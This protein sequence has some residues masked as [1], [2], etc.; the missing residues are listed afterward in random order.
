MKFVH[1]ADMH[2]D[3]PFTM[4]NN[5][6][7][8]EVRRLDQRKI[9]RKVINYIRDNNIPLLFICGDLYEHEYV[10]NATIIYINELFKTIPN[11]KI[12][13]VPGNHDPN[14]KSSYYNKFN[15]NDNVYIFL[16]RID[17]YSY[18]N[19]DIYGYGFNDF[20]MKNS[21]INEIR[22]DDNN[23]INILLT[24]GSLD[25]GNE[26]NKEYNPIYKRDL[27][28]TDFD[29]VGLGHIHKPFCAEI[30]NKLINYIF[31]I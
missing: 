3:A 5:K 8:G 22:V 31:R 4:L 29:Y 17:K 13:I 23:K 10:R 25:S 28:N 26:K 30:N 9:F 1:I 19:V 14:I 20:Y 15:W 12:F 7:L 24:H 6:D 21:K 16:S 11:T 2:F 18:K 27:L